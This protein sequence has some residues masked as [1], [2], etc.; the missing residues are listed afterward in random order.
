[1]RSRILDRSE[2]ISLDSVTRPRSIA[3]IHEKMDDNSLSQIKPDSVDI[4]H[5]SKY[6]SRTSPGDLPYNSEQG[7]VGG[8][9]TIEH[10]RTTPSNVHDDPEM[11]PRTLGPLGYAR[12]IQTTEQGPR[13]QPDSIYTKKRSQSL[14]PDPKHD[15]KFTMN[16]TLAP[17]SK[18]PK[19]RDRSIGDSVDPAVNKKRSRDVESDV[20]GN[21][22]A[23]KIAVRQNA[24]RTPSGGVH[25]SL[26]FKHPQRATQAHT[27]S[28]THAHRSSIGTVLELPERQSTVSES[29]SYNDLG[30][31]EDSPKEG[32]WSAVIPSRLVRIA[33]ILREWT[34]NEA[35]GTILA[36]QQRLLVRDYMSLMAFALQIICT[37]IML[38]LIFTTTNSSGPNLEIILV[39]LVSLVWTVRLLRGGRCS[40]NSFSNPAPNSV[41][42]RL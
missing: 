42:T 26:D 32:R 25:N 41:S 33:K 28:Q 37:L 17:L 15:T 16:S 6:R 3:V 10:Y 20:E 39:S 22:R 34:L 19:S 1:V 21:F 18:R 27:H 38:H 40:H 36:V 29:R 5:P 9:T 11:S 13:T 24:A 4:S 30:A 23:T 7:T 12:N 2:A 8:L 35:N 14:L 31:E